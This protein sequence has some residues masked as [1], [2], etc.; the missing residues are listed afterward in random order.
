MLFTE[1]VDVH[2]HYLQLHFYNMYVATLLL[3]V[4]DRLHLKS[5]SEEKLKL[6]RHSGIN[7]T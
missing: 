7:Y 6:P 2:H 3:T 5:E 1:I 4:A